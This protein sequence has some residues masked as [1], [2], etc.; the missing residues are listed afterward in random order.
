L[1]APTL[2]VVGNVVR[3]AVDEQFQF[4]SSGSEV[5]IPAELVSVFRAESIQEEPVA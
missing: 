3:H 1:P 2:L 4:A 5:S